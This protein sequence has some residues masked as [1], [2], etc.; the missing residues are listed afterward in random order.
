M[1]ESYFK[2]TKKPFDLLPNPDFMY[3]SKSHKRALTYLNYGIK[4][5]TGFILLTG[6]VGSGK[7]TI[8]RDLIKKNHERVLLGK[9]FNTRINSDQLISM[10]NDDF[11]LPV[12]GKDK[13]ELLRDLNVFLIEQYAK[14]SQPTLVIDE[15][16]N[17]SASLLEEVR[18]LSNLETDNAK[19]MQ[20]ILVGQ[21]ELRKT[22]ARTELLQ[23]RQR[24]SINCHLQ[25]LTRP[26][27][28]EYIHHRLDVAGDRSALVFETEAL[29]NIFKYSRGIPRLI[30]I[31]C[32]F[33]M[34]S[35]CAEGLKKL[36]GTM[37]EEIIG[38]LDFENQY[39]RSASGPDPAPVDSG[40]APRAEKDGELASVLL[41]IRSRLE[42]LEKESTRFNTNLMNDIGNRIK[43][44]Q[45]QVAAYRGETDNS[46]G[47]I[48]SKIESLMEKPGPVVTQPVVP[49]EEKPN[50]I[51]RIF[52]N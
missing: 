27:V 31:V 39:W 17:L 40:G 38:E 7:T 51:R 47:E 29:D 35:A 12:H 37:V 52:G 11:G 5:R 1:Y 19:L 49:K 33:L 25:P 41:D 46:I 6:E 32:D 26:E 45:N 10:I 43:S 21:P 30:N 15:A 42:S 36:D 20:I 9:I 23:L 14:G 22:L 48:R 34:L 18:L 28:E 44:V 4:E 13:I 2:L 50:F 3:L 8:I 24:I 16:Q